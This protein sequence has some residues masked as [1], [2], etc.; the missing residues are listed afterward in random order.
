MQNWKLNE[1]KT[2]F[3]ILLTFI[4]IVVITTFTDHLLSIVICHRKSYYR[5]FLYIFWAI[6]LQH[7]WSFTVTANLL[8]VL[9]HGSYWLSF[10]NAVSMTILFPV[11]NEV[12]WT[13]LLELIFHSLSI[14]L[15][16]QFESPLFRRSNPQKSI[17]D[18]FWGLCPIVGLKEMPFYL[19]V[20]ILCFWG[21]RQ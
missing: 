15:G 7:I 13:T 16:L 17:E 20:F 18:T 21:I 5:G 4:E 3:N 10:C 6:F 9:S 12:F 14:V 8:N 11:L 19:F 2:K 1:C